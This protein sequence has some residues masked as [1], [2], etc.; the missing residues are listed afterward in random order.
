[1]TFT[2][3]CQ[4]NQQVK[5][6]MRQPEYAEK[7]MHWIAANPSAYWELRQHNVSYSALEESQKNK[8]RGDIESLQLEQ[9][10]WAGNVDAFL[11]EKVPDFAS[12]GFCPAQYYLYYLKNA[13]DTLINRADLLESVTDNISPDNLLYFQNPPPIKYADDMTLSGSAL[14]ECIPVWADY[15]GIQLT[16]LPALPGDLVWQPQVQMRTGIRGRISSIIPQSLLAEVESIHNEPR[17]YLLHLLSAVGIPNLQGR[18]GKIITRTAYD[19]TREISTL[20]WK[21]GY[22]PLPFRVAVSR[23]NRYTGLSPSLDHTLAE[24]WQQVTELDWYWKPGGWQK[25]S[26]RAAFEPMFFHFWFSILP[27]LWTSFTHSRIYLQKQHPRAMC[28]PSIWGPHETGFIMAAHNERIPV[29]FYQHGACMGDIEN[30]IWDLTDCY[31]SDFQFVYGEG[32]ADYL[33]SRH[34]PSFSRSVSIPVGSAR[35][36]MVS[37]GISDKKVHM[38][39][40]SILGKKDIPLIVY[41][42]GVIINNYF[43]YDYQDFRNCRIFEIRRMVA[44]LFDI[45]PEVHFCYKSFISGGHDPTFMMLKKTS[46][47]CSIIDSIPLTELQWAA[48]LI[49]HEIPGTGM[50][51]GL[52]TDKPLIVYVDHEIYRMPD[53]VKKT[54]GKRV[55]IAETSYE[56]IDTVKQSLENGNFSPLSTPDREFIRAFCT[57]LDDGQSATRAVNAI[58]GIIKKQQR[59][60]ESDP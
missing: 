33:C 18:K 26:L 56:L 10:E 49:I 50:Y 36:D 11:Q 35:L 52:V 16:S 5:W 46:P 17:L 24:V 44:E 51:E 23:S 53:N 47:N 30:T 48:D 40:H 12:T 38:L 3:L 58:E 1:M 60:A 42:P 9:I 21:K 20:L 6:L 54:L 25:W 14:S 57:H 13:W 4:S 39:R 22:D 8:S 27:E 34:I 59:N 41:V 32:A 43:R 15:N 45:H 55:R 29:I 31:Y 2:A 19:Q 7:I 28:V 37:R